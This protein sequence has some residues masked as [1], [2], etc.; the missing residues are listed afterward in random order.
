MLINADINKLKKIDG[1]G[2]KLIEKIYDSI[3]KSLDNRDLC[4]LMAASQIFGRGIGSKKF[5]L[6]TDVYP[7]ILDIV[8]KNGNVKEIINNIIGFDDKTTT[9][10]V[11]NFKLFINWLGELIKLKP[12][13]LSKG[14]KGKSKDSDKGKSKDSDKGKSKSSDKVYSKYA[15]KTIVFTGFRDKE[16]ESILDKIGSKVTTSISKNTDILIAADT[17]EKSSKIVKAN[18][19]NVKIISKDEFYKSLSL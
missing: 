6:I 1:F 5:K 17:T 2:D 11:D 3:N 9:K 7:N 15:N 13:V 19:L 18:E 10:I 14:D 16:V 4:D 12:N 8:N